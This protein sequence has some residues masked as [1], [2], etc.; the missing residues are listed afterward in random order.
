ML[1]KIYIVGSGTDGRCVLP[2][3]TIIYAANSA[4]SRLSSSLDD[5]ITHV[6]S[7]NMFDLSIIK[8]HPHMA[9]RRNTLTNRNP[10]ELVI[11]PSFNSFKYEDFDLNQINYSPKKIAYLTKYNFW[12]LIIKQSRFSTLMHSLPQ[13]K[14]IIYNSLRLVKHLIGYPI[15]PFFLP[16]TGMLALLIAIEKYKYQAEYITVGILP[17][18]DDMHDIGKDFWYDGQHMP[19]TSTEP[20]HTDNI[21]MSCLKKHYHISQM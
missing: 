7:I 12:S 11:Y 20:D 6:A 2:E 21:I 1:K 17:T 15:A 19:L 13:D 4:L 14:G 9:I 18:F 8:H 3:G 5:N 10:S 16:S